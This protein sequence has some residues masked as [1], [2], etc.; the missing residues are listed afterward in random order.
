[1]TRLHCTAEAFYCCLDCKKKKKKVHSIA[2]PRARSLPLKSGLFTGNERH[3]ALNRSSAPPRRRVRQTFRGL[4][5]P[6]QPNSHASQWGLRLKEWGTREYIWMYDAKKTSA[7]LWKWSLR[8]NLQQRPAISLRRV[9]LD[10][11]L[12]ILQAGAAFSAAPLCRRS[13]FSH[14]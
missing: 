14:Y 4:F 11:L 2:A 8:S 6:S 10:E 9:L 5:L 7:I 12:I 1:M 13:S 3:G